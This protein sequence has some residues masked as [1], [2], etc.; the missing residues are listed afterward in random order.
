MSTPT[1]KLRYSLEFYTAYDPT[2]KE[3][4][5]AQLT[6]LFNPHIKNGTVQ[7]RNKECLTISVVESPEVRQ[8]ET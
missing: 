4:V 8:L 3:A 6:T 7:V 1:K 2:V 5:I